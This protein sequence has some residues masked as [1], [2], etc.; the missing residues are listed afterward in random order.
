MMVTMTAASKRASSKTNNSQLPSS[1]VTTVAVG[2]GMAF[3]IHHQASGLKIDTAVAPPAPTI[4]PMS[5]V[6]NPSVAVVSQ[7]PAGSVAQPAPG[8]H[9][10]AVSTTTQGWSTTAEKKLKE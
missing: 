8:P 4:N 1:P 5:P 9:S 10:P 2:G 7:M 6:S 3:H